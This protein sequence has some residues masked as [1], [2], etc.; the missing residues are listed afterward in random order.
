M[1]IGRRF[2]AADL[3]DIPDNFIVEPYV[4]QLEIL[5][6]A[7]VFVTHGGGSSLHEGLWYGVPLVGIAT[8]IE[9]LMN[10][11]RVAEKG[12]CI[13]IETHFLGQPVSPDELRNAVRTILADPAFGKAAGVFQTAFRAAGGASRA[14]DE[15]EN[16]CA[17]PA[18]AD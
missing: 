3:G 11:R 2:T 14:A 15:L 6:R 7:A 18:P 16:L 17:R 12:A 8:Q 1:S 10:V 13:P 4:P 5:K 9:Q